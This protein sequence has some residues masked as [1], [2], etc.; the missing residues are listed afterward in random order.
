MI[1]HDLIQ[2]IKIRDTYFFS[3]IIWFKEIKITTEV[4][5]HICY[6]I[7]SEKSKNL[8]TIIFLTEKYFEIDL[9]F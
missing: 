1:F 9:R 2:S 8:Q 3:I 7:D 6:R 4:L 5:N